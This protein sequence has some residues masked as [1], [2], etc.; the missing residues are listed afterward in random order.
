MIRFEEVSLL[1]SLAVD[2]FSIKPFHVGGSDCSPM[3]IKELLTDWDTHQLYMT[4]IAHPVFLRRPEINQHAF[5][6]INQ[7][8]EHIHPV[9]WS[10]ERM[11]AITAICN[12]NIVSGRQSGTRG[13]E[14]STVCWLFC[15]YASGMGWHGWVSWES[16][17][18]VLF[19]FYGVGVLGAT[20][21]W[22]VVSLS[23]GHRHPRNSLSIIVGPRA[24]PQ[25]PVRLAHL[26]HID[27]TEMKRFSCI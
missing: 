6:L 27:R 13:E 12:V 14:K 4:R 1:R 20:P 17:K 21:T 2:W 23:L 24:V 15:S 7:E 10:S 11:C 9:R 5:D 16:P 3:A 22:K 8:S 26:T 18:F 19:F 25:T